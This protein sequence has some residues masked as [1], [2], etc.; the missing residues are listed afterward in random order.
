M[1]FVKLNTD[2]EVTSLIEQ[3]N[4]E[5]YAILDLETS[6]LNPHVDCIVDVIISGPEGTPVYSFEGSKAKH[7]SI[8][9]VPV[10]AHNFKF[11][12][13]F[14]Y[15]VGVDLRTYGL[16]ADTYLRDHL[17]NETAEHGL[18]AIIQ[19]YWQDN[20]KEVFWKRNKTYHEAPEAE[21]LEYACKDVYY[22]ALLVKKQEELLDAEKIPKALVDQVHASA[23]VF[24]NTELTGLP[25]DVDYLQLEGARVWDLIEK[26]DLKMRF[27]AFVAITQLEVYLYKQACAKYKTEKGRA[28]VGYQTMN[29]DSNQQLG[30]LLYDYLKLPVQLNKKRN[31]T[32]DDEALTKLESRHDFVRLLREYRGYQ[33]L[34]TA[35]IEGS[36]SKMWGGRIYPSFNINGTVTGRLSS[37]IAEGQL[38]TTVGGVKP[39]EQIQPGDLV[40]CYDEKTMQ[41]TISR[42]LQ[43]MNNGPKACVKI[44][45]Q[46]SG[47]GDVG[48]LVCTPDH[49]ILLKSG[50]WAAA[51][52]LKRGDKVA[53]LR[54]SKERRPRLYG[55]NK[56][57][58]QEQL[59]V[60]HKL[61][62]TSSGHIHHI[63]GNPSNNLLNNLT[64]LSS[65]EHV[66][67]HSKE[68]HLNHPE[69]WKHF[70]KGVRKKA[71]GPDAG[72]W[73]HTTR[74]GLLRT[75]ARAKGKPTKTGWDFETFKRK[76]AIHQIDITQVA[77]RYSAAGYL[78]RV[79]VLNALSCGRVEQAASI[80]QIGTRALKKLSAHYGLAY[81]H[82]VLSVKPLGIK[83]VYDLEIEG[84]HNFIVNEVCVHN[85]SPNMQQL[86]KDGG[87]RGIYIAEP[88]HSLICA[89][90]SSQ[91]ICIAAHFSRDVNL[92][93]V[94]NEGASQ[95]D[96]VAESLG[97]PRQ[98]A[99]SLNFAL[100]YGAGVKKVQEILACSEAAAQK[101]YDNYWETFKGLRD[102]SALCHKAVDEG[103]P[104]VSPFGRKRRF[105]KTFAQKWERFSAYRQSANFIIQ[106][107]GADITSGA[108]VDVNRKL[109]E[110]G[111]GRVLFSIHDELVCLIKDE[112]TESA[113]PV[114]IEGML[115]QG[116]KINLTVPLKVDCSQPMKRWSKG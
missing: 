84:Y 93:K 115:A 27:S 24:Y 15:R 107:T 13:N 64:I 20:Y 34:L 17:I 80:L 98:T 9:T 105:P 90:Y 83:N 108:V 8:L 99:K 116:P 92:L 14:L 72:A 104:I 60:K 114:I 30:M 59:L 77:L 101:A 3:L 95:H 50:A 43:R 94:V 100:Q 57:V 28:G 22:T 102:F 87:I 54:R 5:S 103:R 97:I 4:K 85:S 68:Y 55:T 88:G 106:G 47:Q 110:L 49:Q 46:S 2:A 86:P 33:K 44:K 58:V 36:L 1:R 38:V 61:F 73:R 18:D 23:L 6:G 7:L 111:Y 51:E 65:S 113:R 56:F 39:I 74:F 75:L 109:T 32:V 66:S 37:C 16:Y 21:R 40:Y 76:C 62:N 45:W 96:I 67:Q 81:N 31:R 91:E 11:D 25:L 10:V 71:S 35:F 42:V 82:Q 69:H 12:F 53:H 52:T 112:F 29:F 63:D 19:R 26:L 41:P 78:S 79:K 89:D 48:E 70:L